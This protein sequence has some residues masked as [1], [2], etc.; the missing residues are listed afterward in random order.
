MSEFQRRVDEQQRQIEALS[1]GRQ[2]ESPV[3][4]SSMAESEMPAAPNVQM[5]E[6]GPDFPVD[7]IKEQTPC[8]FYQEFKNI[9]LKV[10]VGY[11]LPTL[12]PDGKPP[13]W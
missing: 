12:G 6:G 9:T 11:A 4:S 2:L 5:I 8:D 13:L 10:A 3:Q 7:E 1:R